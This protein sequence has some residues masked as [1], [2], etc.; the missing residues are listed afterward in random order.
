LGPYL[1][2]RKSTHRIDPF[3]SD[4][5]RLEREHAEAGVISTGKKH[6]S[7]H[8]GG[9][10]SRGGGGGG[11]F[12]RLRRTGRRDMVLKIISH[13]YRHN[14]ARISLLRQS[15]SVELAFLPL[16]W[17]A[18]LAHFCCLQNTL[19]TPSPLIPA[20][21]DRLINRYT[22]YQLTENLISR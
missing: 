5:E 4:N 13:H 7:A 10:K 8:G 20:S 22:R 2:K 3:C 18:R 12:G 9:Y 19:I 6:F 21:A 15:L 14:T 1:Y 17:G 16:Y 11:R